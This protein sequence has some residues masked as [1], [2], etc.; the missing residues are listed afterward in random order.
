MEIRKKV[1]KFMEK[2]EKNN[3]KGGEVLQIQKKPKTSWKNARREKTKTE[4]EK[5]CKVVMSSNQRINN[6]QQ[7]KARN[8][9][10]G[11]LHLLLLGP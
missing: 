1:V 7:H 3:K 5:L 6:S 2:K 11:P 4:K 9:L 8:G 10:T